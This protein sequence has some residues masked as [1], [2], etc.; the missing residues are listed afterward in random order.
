MKCKNDNF[1]ALFLLF[2]AMTGVKFA[3]VFRYLL[4]SILTTSVLFILRMEKRVKAKAIVTRQ[5][6]PPINY[7]INDQH[8]NRT[9]NWCIID[10]NTTQMAIS[11]IAHASEIIIS[12]WNW[13]Q[14]QQEKIP[15]GN[16]SSCLIAPMDTIFM[17]CGFYFG[18]LTIWKKV[19]PLRKREGW[20]ALFI[21]HMNC[22]LSDLKP[23][24]PDV[25]WHRPN[26]VLKFDSHKNVVKLQTTIFSSMSNHYNDSFT[27]KD[28]KAIK[29]QNLQIGLINRKGSRIINNMDSIQ[30]SMESI[31]PS[32]NYERAYMEDLSPLEQWRFWASKDIILVA[33]GQSETNAVFLHPNSSIIEIYPPH[34]YPEFY[35]ELFRSICIHHFPY[36]NDIQNW[37]H[38]YSEHSKTLSDRNFYRSVKDMSPNVSSIMLLFQQALLKTTPMS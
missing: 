13:F 10:N 1:L 26:V 16:C 38:D 29:K 25:V 21:Q 28:P 8:F 9:T 19:Q 11:N 17:N 5:S 22:V 3:L 31:F 6:S 18:D 4:V 24:R 35:N 14:M 7:I 37:H 27:L 33:H 15:S 32:G 12:C 2:V 34:Y 20:I 36:F 30:T 23:S